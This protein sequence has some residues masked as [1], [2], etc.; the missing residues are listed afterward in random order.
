MSLPVVRQCSQ[1]K[2]EAHSCQDKVNISLPE[3]QLLFTF[4][5][6]LIV[7]I[8]SS[9]RFLQTQMSA[10]RRITSRFLRMELFLAKKEFSFVIIINQQN[11][12]NEN[13]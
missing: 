2:K 9:F 5:A 13:L 10:V 8:N 4:P 3:G 12:D 11:S 6:F 1:I 7:R